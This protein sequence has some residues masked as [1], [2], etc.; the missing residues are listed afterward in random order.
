MI[1]I[2]C[3]PTCTRHVNF[4]WTNIDTFLTITIIS[5]LPKPCG[6]LI[7]RKSPIFAQIHKNMQNMNI[8]KIS[9][10]Y[11]IY[12]YSEFAPISNVAILPEL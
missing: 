5:L 10:V 11:K 3:S 1:S 7:F 4:F 8:S 9:K 6:N 12:E 2:L